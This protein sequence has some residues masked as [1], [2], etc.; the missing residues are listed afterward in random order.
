MITS[1]PILPLELEHH[2]P[3][4]LSPSLLPPVEVATS[5]CHS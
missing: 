2:Q 1:E 4:S 3:A 5:I